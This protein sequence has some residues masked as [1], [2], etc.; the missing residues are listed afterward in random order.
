MTPGVVEFG[1]SRTEVFMENGWSRQY[2]AVTPGSAG[3]RGVPHLLHN[4]FKTFNVHG[5]RK[6]HLI[7][8]RQAVHYS[9]SRSVVYLCICGGSVLIV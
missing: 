3:V 7:A 4:N 9:Y 1:C 6:T 5:P 2:V 8:W